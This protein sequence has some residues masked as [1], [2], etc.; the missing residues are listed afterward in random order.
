MQGGKGGVSITNHERIFPQIT[1]HVFYAISRITYF[2]TLSQKTIV[3]NYLIYAA[4]S[5]ISLGSKVFS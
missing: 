5:L 4:F 2:H 1:N 3:A